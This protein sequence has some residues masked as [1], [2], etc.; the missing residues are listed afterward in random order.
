M[1][2]RRKHI[3]RRKRRNG[4][5]WTLLLFSTA[6]LVLTVGFYGATIHSSVPEPTGDR[7]SIRF[8][9]YSVKW[10]SSLNDT[11]IGLVF[12]IEH[13]FFDRAGLTISA[14]DGTSDEDTAAAVASND[15]LIGQIS[16]SGFL[17][18]RSLGS[19]IVAFAASQIVNSVEIYSLPGKPIALPRDLTGKI[20]GYAP[21]TDCGPIL[22]A[23]IR[24]HALPRSELKVTQEEDLASRLLRGDADVIVGKWE[25][26]G[27]DLKEAG[28]RF[29]TTSPDALGI[30]VPG[31]VY[32]A[33]E[34]MIATHPEI[35]ERFLRGLFA[36]W[37]AAYQDFN[38][39]VGIGDQRVLPD[40]NPVRVAE[41]MEQLRP[42][43]RPLGTR[44]GELDLARLRDLQSLLLSQRL[45]AKSLDFNAAANFTLVQETY[46]ERQKLLD[47]SSRRD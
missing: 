44:M 45:M 11:A 6:T 33:S 9:V 15:R 38:V 37:D 39:L 5:L 35:G 2:L 41:T 31:S 34:N 19:K 43:L 32:I 30:H 42:F 22:E 27:R 26:E 40:R 10:N 16:A 25:K 12:G 46:R 28:I 18:A 3:R 23:I 47:E 7:A 20:I 17:R 1:R 8:P 29:R 21:S 14:I 24:R 36:A 13:G 4:W